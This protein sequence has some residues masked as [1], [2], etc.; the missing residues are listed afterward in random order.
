MTSLSG[1]LT[2][3]LETTA[4]ALPRAE[5]ERRWS[6]PALRAAVRSGRVER[7]LPG[8]YAAS[9]HG[10]AVRTRASAIGAWTG[11]RGVIIGLGAAHLHGLIDPPPTLRVTAAPGRPTPA[12]PWVTVL[13]TAIEIPAVTMG[14]DVHATFRVALPA[15][16]VVT[17]FAELDPD[18]GAALVYRAAQHR[19]VDAQTLGAAA[20]A[21]PRVRGRRALNA[22][23][24]AVGAGAE[25]HLETV[26]LR[27]V[28]HTREFAR[29]IRQHWVRIEGQSF[30]LDMFD[31]ATLTAIELDGGTHADPEQRQRDIARDALLASRGILTLR[32]SWRQITQDPRQ[33]R[34]LVR[35]VLRS[36]GT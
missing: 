8:V 23:I 29:L 26:G 7:V 14:G 9:L 6:R 36:R 31:A 27:E 5:L 25:S 19:L 33:C 35:A 4:A 12:C 11:R 17:A 20:A 28:F 13:R 1:S 32:F 16:A 34:S 30:R 18:A 2:A 15:Y 24:A 21:L 10:R 22:L 3:W